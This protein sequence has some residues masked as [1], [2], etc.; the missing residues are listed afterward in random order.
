MRRHLEL[1][2]VHACGRDLPH[3]LE[4][5]RCL[6]PADAH[7]GIR[8]AAFVEKLVGHPVLGGEAQERKPAG[9]QPR[10]GLVLRAGGVGNLLRHPQCEALETGSEEA[11]LRLEELVDD[12]LRN[13]RPTRQLVHRRLR[14]AAL[15]KQLLA[16]LDELTCAHGPWHA[17][18]PKILYAS[19]SLHLLTVG[20][21]K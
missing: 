19:G 2:R 10:L 3:Q 1:A 17:T 21:R 12:R 20:Y 5:Q 8:E 6:A 18:V 11:L 16:E 15:R 9:P 14:K 7:G 13:A 4:D